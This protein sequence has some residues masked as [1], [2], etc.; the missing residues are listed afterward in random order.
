M[1]DFDIISF[2]IGAAGG[3]GVAL[4]IG[5][6]KFSRMQNEARDAYDT[7]RVRLQNAENIIEGQAMELFD[8]ATKK[9]TR[10]R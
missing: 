2:V 6:A 8:K 7:L 9:T 3:F 5:R 10:K 4:A 1:F